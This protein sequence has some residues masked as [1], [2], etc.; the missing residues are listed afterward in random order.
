MP[1]CALKKDHVRTQREGGHGQ[2]KERG[3]WEAATAD[4]LSVD[5]QTP[6]L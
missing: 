4:T 6:E 2:A 1:R 3:L 5:S